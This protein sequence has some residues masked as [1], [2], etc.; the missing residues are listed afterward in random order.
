MIIKRNGLADQVIQQV[1]GLVA[2][3]TYHI[4]D[5]LP[6]EGELGALFGVGRSTVR[7]AMRVLASRGLVDV[8]HGE[9]TFVASAT[10]HES[11]EERLGRAALHEIYE[12][13]LFLELALSELATQRRDARDIAAM[14]AC[15]KK[16]A[17][18]IRAGDVERYAEAD[19]A[20]HLAV[21]KAAKNAALFDMYESFVATVRPVLAAATTPEY[22]RDEKDRLHAALCEAI[23]AGNI[24][25][26]RRLVRRHLETSLKRLGADLD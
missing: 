11:F 20:F 15:L 19:F 24:A 18:A 10:L 4:G 9:G 8:R 6:S 5:R 7:E 21:A 3:G 17:Q 23:A 26:T 25:A 12:V 1:R 22:V 16:R 2:D 14:R 13:R